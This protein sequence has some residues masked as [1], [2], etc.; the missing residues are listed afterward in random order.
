MDHPE[1]PSSLLWFC[2]PIHWVLSTFS[3]ANTGG[4]TG[5]GGPRVGLQG[6]NTGLQWGDSRL[7]V[8]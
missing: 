3:W 4:A 5:R 1:R 8:R 2:C 7:E 6:R